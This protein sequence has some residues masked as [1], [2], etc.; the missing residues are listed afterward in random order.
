M[1]RETG[2]C[3]KRSPPMSHASNTLCKTLLVQHHLVEGGQFGKGVTNNTARLGLASVL[4]ACYGR[5]ETIYKN[6][7]QLDCAPATGLGYFLQKEEFPVDRKRNFVRGD[8]TGRQRLPQVNTCS[9]RLSSARK[10]HG[11]EQEQ[12][13]HGLGSASGSCH[14]GQVPCLPCVPV[15]KRTRRV[16]GFCKMLLGAKI[17]VC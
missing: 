12:D 16:C 1:N 13:K 11:P 5:T 17:G 15:C 10:V 4:R 9:P 7:E 6:F 14:L 2:N 8:E 3:G